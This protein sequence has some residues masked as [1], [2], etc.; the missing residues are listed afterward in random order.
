MKPKSS[1]PLII[2]HRG[3]SRLAPE[4][5]LAAFRMA[6]DAGADGIE[7][8]VRLARDGV[9]VVIHDAGLL[10]LAGI[11]K[12]TAELTSGE[13]Q[14]L[15]VGSW[16]YGRSLAETGGAE[17]GDFSDQTVPT[18]ARLLEFLG[19][20]PGLLYIELKCG[21]DAVEPLTAAVCRLVRDSELLP[22]IVLKSFRH[23]AIA[24]AKVLI[25]EIRT[26]AL[27]AP[28]ILNVIGK[29]KYLLSKAEDSL[30]DEI[31]LHYSLATKKLVARAA[32]RGLPTVIWTIDNPRWV[33]RGVD[34]GVRGIITNNPAALLEKRRELG[35][36]PPLSGD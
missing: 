36:P 25:P 13:L 15:D 14:N 23:R 8:D 34:L 10:R 12:D 28:K 35:G 2:A 1:N 5:T 21:R 31:S 22:R 26:A 30:A 24:R 18:L 17:A 19:G 6:V 16:F 29:K 20:Y 32:K 3:A 11:E 9:P 33:R 7:L 27:F 4:N